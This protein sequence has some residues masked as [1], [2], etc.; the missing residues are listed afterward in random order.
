MRGGVCLLLGLLL[1]QHAYAES[2]T[3]LVVGARWLDVEGFE[4]MRELELLPALQFDAGQFSF[5]G[6]ARLRWRERAVLAGQPPS[7]DSYAQ[8]SRPHKLNPR[9]YVEVRD[10]YAQARIGSIRLRIGKQFVNWGTLDGIKVLDVLNPQ[11]FAEFILEDFDASRISTWSARV[12]GTLGRLSWDLFW[13]PDASVH[14]LPDAGTAYAFTAPRFATGTD[15]PFR[16]AREDAW[17]VRAGVYLGA[18]EIRALA[19]GGAEHEPVI[20]LPG[21]V[22]SLVAPRRRLYG[23]QLE[24]SLGP[25]VLRG[26]AAWR[27][28]RRF[29]TIPT[30]TSAAVAIDE[31]DQVTAGVGLDYAAP[32]GLFVNAQVVYDEVLDAPTGLIRPERDI[33]GTLTLRRTFLRERLR[34]DVRVYRTEA[35]DGLLRLALTWSA[36]PLGDVGLQ[37]DRFHGTA[38]GLFG[39][40]RR[41]DS[42]GV[43]WRKTF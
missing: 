29:N 4:A 37:I 15:L 31:A 26:E 11:N 21:G 1:T 14:D 18:W 20:R 39:Q 33:V 22:P 7:D 35:H 24:R 13:S 9:T 28:A 27:H 10:A 43:T 34:T 40:F 41:S 17:G 2:L 42:V 32:F 8:A 36:E 23:L 3:E 25:L 12:D 16:R 19:I 38:N 5:R 6:S 30:Q